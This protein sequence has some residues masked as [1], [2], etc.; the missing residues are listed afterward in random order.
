MR[1]AAG[2]YTLD[3]FDT[4]V[5]PLLAAGIQ[6]WFNVGYGNRVYLP[7]APH[8]TAVGW[9]PIF[10][11]EARAGWAGFVTAL[12]AHYAGRVDW[13]EVWNEPDITA[14]WAPHVSSATDYAALVKLTA[15]GLRRGSAT[16]KVV[17]GAVAHSLSQRGLA[18]F[19]EAFEQ[20]MGEQ[21]D[22]ISYHLYTGLPEPRY[23]V[24][25]PAL[26]DL[27]HRYRP[28]LPIWQG[29]SG[30]PSVAVE[31]Q[32]LSN[33]DWTEARQAK[34]NTRRSILDLAAGADLVTFFH[35]S[36]FDFYIVKD[37]RVEKT[38]HFGLIGGPDSTPKP[39]YYAAQSLCTLFAG[40]P[41]YTGQSVS[42]ARRRLTASRP[43][44]AAGRVLESSR[45]GRSTL[46]PGPAR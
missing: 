44:T 20:G 30:A 21:I 46:P 37:R 25:L 14:F 29:E 28:G 5:D 23:A 38:Y 19:E 39:A 34:W 10:T 16:A 1:A 13:F 17:G 12:A 6:P 35:A 31:G 2:V 43:P 18:Y 22:A 40:E 27:V 7:D 3:W 41:R 26:R 8:F 45:T 11:A 24:N 36:D 42:R 4:I 32:A 15:E 33:C 9:S